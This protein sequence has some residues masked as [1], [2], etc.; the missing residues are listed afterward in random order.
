[1]SFSRRDA[2]VLGVGG[3]AVLPFGSAAIA[4]P[5][6]AEIAE[7]T[8]GAAVGEGDLA[9]EAP[10]LAENGNF[11][12]IEITAPGAE[13]VM[14]VAPENPDIVVFHLSFGPKAAGNRFKTRVRMAKTQDLVLTARAPDGTFTQV[15]R[16]VKVTAGG[17]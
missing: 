10:E 12:Q 11:V 6:D 2:L 3:L 16:N 1:M 4:A 7:F 9:I 13:E 17:C 14:L 5:G 8:G 15:R